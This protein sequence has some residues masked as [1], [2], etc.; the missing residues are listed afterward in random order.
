MPSANG[1]T[2]A[3]VSRLAED[4]RRLAEHGRQ[5]IPE[6]V[7]Q[8]RELFGDRFDFVRGQL[9][10][11][12]DEASEMAGE[13]LENAR[14]YVVERVQERPFTS[15]LAALGAGFLLGLLLSGSRK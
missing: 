7:A 14:L 9:R 15:T 6:L 11:R 5:A 10:E 2:R 13:S 4:A 1:A 3:D 8:A 12:G